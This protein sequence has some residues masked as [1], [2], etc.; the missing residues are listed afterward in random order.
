MSV[1]TLFWRVGTMSLMKV[2]SWDN[3]IDK[4]WDKVFNER[5]DNVMRVGTMS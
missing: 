5:W 2:G 4:S 3:D 1:G